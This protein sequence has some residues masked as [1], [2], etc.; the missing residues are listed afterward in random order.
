MGEPVEEVFSEVDEIEI[1]DGESK[2][3]DESELKV[4]KESST[5]EEIYLKALTSSIDKFTNTTYDLKIKQ[6]E[7]EKDMIYKNKLEIVKV[8]NKAFTNLKVNDYVFYKM[9]IVK[10]DINR[11]VWK[12][13]KI[14]LLDRIG[15][16]IVFDDGT[17]TEHS[18]LMF[19]N[20]SIQIIIPIISDITPK[21]IEYICPEFKHTFL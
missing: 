19:I 21:L 17:S 20:T 18:G 10:K 5:N 1:S 8:F 15:Q 11:I 3:Q 2:I 13:K 6:A 12:N 4:D 14:V 16:F 9:T 7:L